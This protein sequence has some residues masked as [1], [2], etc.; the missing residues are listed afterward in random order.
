MNTPLP[1][2]TDPVLECSASDALDLIVQNSTMRWC[3]VFTKSVTSSLFTFDRG[4]R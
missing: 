2:P 4:P 1:F 3:H